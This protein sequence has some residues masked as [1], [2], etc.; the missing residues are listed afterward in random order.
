MQVWEALVLER[1]RLRRRVVV[2]HGRGVHLAELEA[3]ALAVFE[4]DG[5]KEDHWRYLGSRAATN[6][7][8]TIA[9]SSLLLSAIEV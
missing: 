3:H 5:G 9:I 1:A 6:M 8:A 2:E 4:V 7:A